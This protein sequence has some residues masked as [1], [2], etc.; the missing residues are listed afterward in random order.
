MII[1]KA[2]I[3]FLTKFIGM[4]ITYS[5]GCFVHKSVTVETV[6]LRVDIMLSPLSRDDRNLTCKFGSAS[7]QFAGRIY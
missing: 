1:R 7:T 5:D 3:H 6:V 2:H 4:T